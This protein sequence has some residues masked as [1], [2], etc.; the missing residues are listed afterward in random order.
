MR[1]AL[2]H[3]DL[4]WLFFVPADMRA[5]AW[6]GAGDGEEGEPRADRDAAAAD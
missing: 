6:K 1:N 2:A 3:V 4:T 5:L